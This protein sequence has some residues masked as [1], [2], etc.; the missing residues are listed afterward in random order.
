[1]V[2]GDDKTHI[3]G[4]LPV[5]QAVFAGAGY[6]H[7]AAEAQ[8]CLKRHDERQIAAPLD[9]P[10]GEQRLIIDKPAAVAY[11]VRLGLHDRAG[12][13]RHIFPAFEGLVIPEPKRLDAEIPAADLKQA[14]DKAQIIG[15][16]EQQCVRP[17]RQNILLCSQRI[18][19]I[20]QDTPAGGLGR[21]EN[22]VKI[23]A[24]R[25]QRVL[26]RLGR[27]RGGENGIFVQKHGNHP[28]YKCR[29]VSLSARAALPTAR[30][31]GRIQDAPLHFFYLF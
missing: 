15:S 2:V 14:V 20:Q 26:H 31:H 25:F 5:E 10:V 8:Q 1:M 12:R 17:G 28:I 6:D 19:Y 22:A 27:R 3:G 18:V 7:V 21:A 16:R 13:Y 23:A 9:L 24:Q 30:P 4:G 11:P 29:G